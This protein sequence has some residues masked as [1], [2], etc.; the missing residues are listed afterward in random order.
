MTINKPTPQFTPESLYINPFSKRRTF[1]P[2]NGSPVY[3]TIERNTSPTGVDI[4][5]AYARYIASGK[6]YS[7]ISFVKS[8][9]ISTNDFTALCRIMLGMRPEEI[10]HHL[11]L[12]YA[13][14]LLRYTDLSVAQ[15]ARLSSAND[16]SNLCRL[17]RKYLRCTPTERRKSLRKLGD[18]GRYVL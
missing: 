10:H 2:E 18:L 16:G 7:S 4:L 13:D 9:G 11:V 17:M 3:H 6:R 8:E 5:D 12:R 14:E 15:I 1:D